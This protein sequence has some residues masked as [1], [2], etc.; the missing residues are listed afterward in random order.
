[1]DFLV[2]CLK[3]IRNQLFPSKLEVLMSSFDPA[4]ETGDIV[5]KLEI[6]HPYS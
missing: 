3:K 6:W 5:S 1:M 2:N 4:L